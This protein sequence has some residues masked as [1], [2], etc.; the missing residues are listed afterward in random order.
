MSF[1]PNRAAARP[2]AVFQT[3]GGT[4]LKFRHPTLT[5]Q[6]S[7]A[8]QI[9]E[10]DV[11][12]AVR[13]NDTFLDATAAQDNS[14]M[15]P[16]VNG[17]TITITNHLLAGQ[18]ALSVIRTTGLVRTGDFVACALLVVASKDKTGGTFTVIEEID[19]QRIITVFYGVSFKNVPH[20]KKA[21]NSVVPYPVTMNYAGFFQGVG[22]PTLD[23][24][25]IWAVGSKYGLQAQYMPFAVQAGQGDGTQFY[26]PSYA[27]DGVVGGV[28]PSDA[29]SQAA[30]DATEGAVPAAPADGIAPGTTP[31][32]VSW[33]G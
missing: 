28:D 14:V 24:S 13:L 26:S 8:S 19:G 3:S 16:L 10:V 7:N 21:G 20:L 17:S 30:D 32:R 29:D 5:G 12:G 27:Q 25:I 23:E 31:V 9:D 33:G 22:D 18:M 15:E 11:S 4:V 1:G 2:R 6:I